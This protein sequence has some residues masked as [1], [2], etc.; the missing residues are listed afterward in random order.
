MKFAS[1]L[2]F[3]LPISPGA[4]QWH[5]HHCQKPWS[6]DL[7]APVPEGGVRLPMFAPSPI[8]LHALPVCKLPEK[9]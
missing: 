7:S 6:G 4:P 1:R 8:E 2:V 5:F 9:R 3:P